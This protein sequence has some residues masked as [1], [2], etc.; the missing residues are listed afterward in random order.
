MDL[1]LAIGGGQWN[2]YVAPILK[3]IGG[4]KPNENIPGSSRGGV[5]LVSTSILA[6]ERE[7]KSKGEYP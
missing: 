7:C 1:Y 4:I 6:R 3:E 2:R 5:E